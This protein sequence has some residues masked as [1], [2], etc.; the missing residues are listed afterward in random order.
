MPIIIEGGKGFDR[1]ISGVLI[2]YN[3]SEE[4]FFDFN[5]SKTSLSP[6]AK[7]IQGIIEGK[8]KMFVSKDEAMEGW[9]IAEEVLKPLREAPLLLYAKETHYQDNFLEQ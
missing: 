2:S 4:R 8:K 6:H 7:V 1:K 3:D 5:K 9:R